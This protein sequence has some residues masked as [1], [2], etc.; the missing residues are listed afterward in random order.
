[1]Q[2]TL[3]R[4]L[5][6]AANIGVGADNLGLLSDDNP[7]GVVMITEE[8]KITFAN[9]VRPDASSVEVAA[10]AAAGAAAAADHSVG[11]DADIFM[12]TLYVC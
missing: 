11:Y 12:T 9:K 7:D 2:L 1:M 8:G 5:T 4:L 6:A 10:V 3:K